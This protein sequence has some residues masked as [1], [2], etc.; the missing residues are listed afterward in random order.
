MDLTPE[1]LITIRTSLRQSILRAEANGHGRS[2]P[3]AAMRQLYTRIDQAGTSRRQTG[4]RVHF[5]PAAPV[6]TAHLIPGGG[7]NG[8][9][10]EGGASP[11]GSKPPPFLASPSQAQGARHPPDPISTPP[12]PR[13]RRHGDSGALRTYLPPN[14]QAE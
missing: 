6:R 11:T 5:L 10:N 7:P 12:R 8:L 9:F 14:R 1:E 3:L 2:E 4:D 13:K